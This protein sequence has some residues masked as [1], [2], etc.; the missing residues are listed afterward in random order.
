MLAS[1]YHLPA[2]W[3]PHSACWLAWPSHDDLWGENLSTVRATFVALCEAIASPVRADNGDPPEELDILVCDAK[4]R[5][6][7]EEALGHLSPRT[8]P[9]AFGDIWVRDTGPIFVR[10]EDGHCAAARFSFN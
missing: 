6:L 8:H 7:A 2:E 1:R 5:R 10:G 9:I 3:E 4:Q